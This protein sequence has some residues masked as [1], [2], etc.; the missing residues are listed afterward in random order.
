MWDLIVSVP[1][2][3]LSVYFS[4]V[5]FVK[6]ISNT[7][8]RKRYCS[9]FLYFDVNVAFYVFMCFSYSPLNPL[10]KVTFSLSSLRS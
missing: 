5:K 6:Q 8:T 7:R 3:C 4:Y 2:H 10:L 9:I 1:D